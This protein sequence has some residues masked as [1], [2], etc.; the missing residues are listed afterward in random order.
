MALVRERVVLKVS[1]IKVFSKKSRGQAIV[2]FALVLPLLLFVVVGLIEAGRAIFIYSSVTNA[3]RE[4]ARYGTAYGVNAGGIA[5]FRDCAGIRAAAR[6][7][8]FYLP[9]DD[10][11]ITYDNGILPDPGNPGKFLDPVIL[12]TCAKDKDVMPDTFELQCGD[13]ITVTITETY[14]PMLN[15]I[16]LEPQPINSSST[17]TYLGIITL[18]KDF[19]CP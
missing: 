13:R 2:E 10:I 4:A 19:K 6:R 12:D 14:R 9:L 15:L 18:D 5:K 11:E 8:G 17:R 16:P 7:T 3:S 1:M